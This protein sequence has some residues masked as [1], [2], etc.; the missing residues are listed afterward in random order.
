MVQERQAA[1]DSRVTTTP[2]NVIMTPV[3]SAGDVLP[4]LAIGREL[5]ARGHRVTVITA[6]PFGEAARRSGLAFDAFPSTD[7]FDSTVLDP[8]LWDPVAG[9]RVVMRRVSQY[10]PEA[11]AHVAAHHVPGRTVLVGHSIAFAT[12][13]FEERNGV[14]AVTLHLSPSVFRSDHRQPVHTPGRDFSAWPRLAKRAF[15]WGIDRFVLDP[16]V[17]PALNAFRTTHGLAPVHR[18]MRSWLHSPNQVIGLFPEWF[19]PR[20]PDWPGALELVGFPLDGGSLPALD[21]HLTNFLDAGEPPLLFTPGSANRQ[22]SRFFAAAVSAARRLGRRALLLSRYSEQIPASLPEGIRHVAWAPLRA[23]APQCAAL[24]H[25]GGIGTS[26]HALAAGVP[27][28][29]MPM[30]FDQPDNAAR[31]ER[32]GVARWITPDRFDG[33]RVASAL[34]SLLASPVTNVACQR[35][36]QATLADRAIIRAADVIESANTAPSARQ[37]A[38]PG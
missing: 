2:L 32:L 26:A 15:W 36:R 1:G 27:Q 24:V 31:L 11:Y 9:F 8:K 35:W 34:A 29:V 18:V 37:P 16:H 7:V 17:V 4:F 12:R 19:G 20:Q 25:H 14:P 10:L 5:R 30:G 13:V 21:T 6:E 23:L 22:A 38:T 3:G 28:L 33:E